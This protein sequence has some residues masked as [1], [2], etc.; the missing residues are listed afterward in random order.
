MK[1]LRREDELACQEVVELVTDYLEGALPRSQRRRF[2]AHL[3]GCENCAEYL[4]QMR[5]TIRLTGRLRAGDL[6][7]RDAGGVHSSIPALANRRGLNSKRR[8]V[9]VVISGTCPALPRTAALDRPR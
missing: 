9:L 3:A 2:E 8:T 7:A 1:I 5:A 4:E 6:T